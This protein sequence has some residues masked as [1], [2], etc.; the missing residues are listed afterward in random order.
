IS[1]FL[2]RCSSSHVFGSLGHCVSQPKHADHT[3]STACVRHTRVIHAQETTR[4]YSNYMLTVFMRKQSKR[5]HCLTQPTANRTRENCRPLA[6]P[7]R[8]TFFRYL[9]QDTTWYDALVP[10]VARGDFPDDCDWHLTADSEV[11]CQCR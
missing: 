9:T 10:P 11:Q 4:W 8:H 7:P 2:T 1:E 6:R 3:P 5:T